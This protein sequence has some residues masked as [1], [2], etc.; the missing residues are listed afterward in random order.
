MSS[1]EQEKEVWKLKWMKCD[2]DLQWFFGIGEIHQSLAVSA[3][4]R[5]YEPGKVRR[6]RMG[7]F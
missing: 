2:G 7:G 6:M 4:S 1:E 3:L 5:P